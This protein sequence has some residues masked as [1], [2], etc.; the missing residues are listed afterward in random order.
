MTDLSTTSSDTGSQMMEKTIDIKPLKYKLLF[1]ASLE[2]RISIHRCINSI[3]DF[4]SEIFCLLLIMALF[5]LLICFALVGKEPHEENF[6]GMIFSLIL[7]NW[8]SLSLYL[9]FVLAFCYFILRA[10][11]NA[12]V[13]VVG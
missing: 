3:K 9:G 7:K 2:M 8:L 5:P 1:H 4:C 10:I 6:S 13:W 11:G 12:V